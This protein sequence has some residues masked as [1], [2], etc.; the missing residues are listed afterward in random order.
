MGELL[1]SA[2][3]TRQTTTPD[4]LVPVPLHQERL[5][6]RGYNQAHKIADIIGQRLSI[7]INARSVQRIDQQGSQ[8][9]LN[10]R[11]R[12]KNLRRAFIAVD[13]VAGKNIAIVD[14]VYTTG[15]T[16]QALATTLLKADA[17]SVSVWAFARTP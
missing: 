6:E 11:D 5:L 2:I 12:A 14:D 10:A 17:N 8:V 1:A 4:F 13:S 15:A 16:A 7:P 3:A 9:T